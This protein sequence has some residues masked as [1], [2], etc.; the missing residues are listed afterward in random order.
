[1][2]AS[3]D[4]IGRVLTVMRERIA[5]RR[6][7]GDSEESIQAWW[8]GYQRGVPEPDTERHPY[9]LMPV[10]RRCQRKG[11]REYLLIWPSEVRRG[12]GRYCSAQCVYRANRKRVKST[13][14]KCGKEFEH[15]PAKRR[16]NCSR[17]CNG[18]ARDRVTIQCAICG[19]DVV[20]TPRRNRK[21][22][23]LNCSARAQ[24]GKRRNA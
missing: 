9:A 8:D 3:A 18:T 13:C 15:Y 20:D 10:L 19:V 21:F 14:R 24:R 6:A 22:C 23:S 4:E 1:M 7:R 12:L 11:C 2:R 5:Q 16:V 17:R